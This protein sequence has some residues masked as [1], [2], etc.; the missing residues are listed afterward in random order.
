ML[1]PT[2]HFLDRGYTQI[3]ADQRTGTGRERRVGGDAAD[4]LEVHRR[5]R[6]AGVEPVPTEPE[7][8]A[9]ERGQRHVVTGWHAA[10][11]TLEL[12][13]ETGPERDRPGDGEHATDRVDDGRAGEVT[14][15]RGVHAGMSA[16]PSQ[17]FGP[18]TQ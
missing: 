13:A 12:P 9:T 18:Q 17:P 11:V 16:V 6:A 2:S 7:D 10:T 5:E 8:D 4:A 1:M 14:E 15:R 3:T